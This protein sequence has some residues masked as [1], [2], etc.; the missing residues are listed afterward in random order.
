M[1]GPATYLCAYVSLLPLPYII[2]HRRQAGGEEEAEDFL[3]CWVVVSR[4]GCAAAGPAGP[5][6]RSVAVHYNCLLL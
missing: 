3:L 6:R 4:L 1:S 2:I 5:W